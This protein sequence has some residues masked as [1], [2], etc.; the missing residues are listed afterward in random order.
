MNEPMNRRPTR[1][2]CGSKPA[3]I[4]RPWMRA[5]SSGSPWRR[6]AVASGTCLACSK[7]LG[8][9]T[10]EY[11]KYLRGTGEAVYCAASPYQQRWGG[12]VNAKSCQRLMTPTFVWHERE[13][14][15]D[16]P[17][18]SVLG[19]KPAMLAGSTEPEPDRSP[20]AGETEGFAVNLL[21]SRSPNAAVALAAISTVISVGWA[22]PARAVVAATLEQKAV[23]VAAH[24]V[25]K[26]YQWGAAGPNAF[27]CSGLT[28]YS[29]R[30]AGKYL[31]RT[32][33]EQY[34]AVRHIPIWQIKP[35][36]LIFMASSGY[37]T[38]V[39][40]IDHV[41]IWAGSNSWYVAHSPGTTITRQS[42][43]THNLWA[44]RP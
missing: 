30:M 10:G 8:S 2:F 22:T 36:D 18:T 20:S 16:G 5:R 37:S 14:Q 44:G 7:A 25:G 11:A 35:G 38:N 32:A 15:H 28:Q 1:S 13:T 43:W 29:F 27:D 17:R 21:A 19:V 40:Q 26:P 9:G 3:A 31:P 41:G 24:Q 34:R 39:N 6:S 42:M 23:I 33:M 12:R 4:L